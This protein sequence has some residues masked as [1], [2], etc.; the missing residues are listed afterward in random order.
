MFDDSLLRLWRTGAECE[1]FRSQEDDYD[2]SDFAPYIHKPGEFALSKDVDVALWL[3]YR[4][5]TNQEPL[6]EVYDFVI[7]N[8][9]L[10]KEF[11][12]FQQSNTCPEFSYL[13]VTKLME[14]WISTQEST[15]IVVQFGQKYASLHKSA[16]DDLVQWLR[17]MRGRFEREGRLAFQSLQKVLIQQASP[18]IDP[19]QPSSVNGNFSDM[20]ECSSSACF[21]HPSEPHP[22]NG[23]S[24]VVGECFSSYKQLDDKVKAYE[25]SRSVQL[26]H[27]DSRTL[28]AAKKRAPKRVD[29]ANR[30]L[31]YYNI[32]FTC[33]FGGKKFRSKSTGL[34]TH[35]RTF[36]QDCSA[37]I[38]L[39]LSLDGKFL[40]V[41]EV[42]EDH[43]HEVSKAIYDHLP[44]QRRLNECEKKE[45]EGLLRMKVNSKLRT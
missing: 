42:K 37:G 4:T 5:F 18:V 32:H 40:K 13:P 2:E 28:E 45:A 15:P 11:K 3:D 20:A 21:D 36:K 17:N 23:C 6:E 34:R 16:V 33:M 9:P 44:R 43:N 25:K 29:G 41:T 26:G 14:L 31:K 19:N 35:Q 22:A 1:G 24:F 8:Q 39:C 7:V 38:K 12:E 10:L 30:E 27:R